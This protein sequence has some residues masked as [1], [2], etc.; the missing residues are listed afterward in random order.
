VAGNITIA[1]DC[2]GGDKA[3]GIVIDGAAQAL[4][5]HS[6]LRFLLFGDK[7][8][9]EPLLQAAPQLAGTAEIRHTEEEVKPTDGPAQALRQRRN[10]SM[11]LALNAVK[12]GEAGAIVS[13]GN[14]GA[15]MAMSKFVLKTLPGID[16]PAICSIMPT[17]KGETAMLDLGANIECDEDNLVQ[18]AI[19]GAALARI[20]MNRERPSVGLL[21]VGEEELK[22]GDSLK[23]AAQILRTVDLPIKF[24]GFVEGDD[25]AKGTTDVV[26]TDGFSGNV[27][28]KAIEGTSKLFSVFLRN[29]LTA[30]VFARLGYL[31]ARPALGALRRK[32]D[33]RRY[34][35]GIFLGLNGVSVKSHGGTDGFGFSHAI[36]LAHDAVTDDLI[37]RISADVAKLVGLSA[38]DQ[39]A[40]VS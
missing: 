7:A 17:M 6:N 25:I 40:A 24:H 29:A 18:F 9:I 4:A 12:D 27:T 35:G 32:I 5:R 34:N 39:E 14:T 31:L 22:G 3:P 1:L 28:L 10:S 30:T 15:L 33:P 2:M 26:V 16:R 11:R 21:N 23:A 36:E 13:A 37:G 38:Q 19:M 8:R 20:E